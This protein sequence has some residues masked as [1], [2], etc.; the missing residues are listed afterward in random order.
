MGLETLVRSG[1]VL[2]WDCIGML[3]RTKRIK[4]FKQ[5]KKRRS[6]LLVSASKADETDD[7]VD[8]NDQCVWTGRRC[9]RNCFGRR[10]GDYQSCQGCSVYASCVGGRIYN[11]RP[12]APATPALR[13]DD[14]AKRCLYNSTTCK[15]YQDIESKVGICYRL[16]GW[17]ERRKI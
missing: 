7:W 3:N 12:C 6:V 2:R 9:I 5:T 16:K 17:I 4:T 11:R 1:C 13:W 15:C 14:D 8:R 10:D